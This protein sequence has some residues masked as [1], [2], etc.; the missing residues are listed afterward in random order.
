MFRSTKPGDPTCW[1]FT[2]IPTRKPKMSRGGRHNAELIGNDPL[3]VGAKGWV[4]LPTPA[5]RESSSVADLGFWY[6]IGEAWAQVAMA[7]CRTDSPRILDIGCGCAKMARFFVMNP[8]VSYLGIDVFRP[9]IEWSQQAFRSL[10]RF[11]FL[12]F[13][14][15][16]PL[17]NGAGTLDVET[18]PVPAESGQ[19]DLIICASLF[20]HLLEP[21]FKHYMRE[22]ARCLSADGIGIVSTHNEPAAGARFSGKE[23]RID[24]ADDY[25]I[26]I[27]AEAGLRAA[28]VETVFGQ[29]VFE[30]S[31]R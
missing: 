24:I 14:V 17:Y 4:P 9:S 20:T 25:F 30:L 13:N 11:T 16:S 15:H 6:A 23:T 22:V 29:E 12:H 2:T 27:A 8:R 28:K 1:A 18:A 10:P 31:R 26:E 7:R 19:A 3:S 5:L 21:S